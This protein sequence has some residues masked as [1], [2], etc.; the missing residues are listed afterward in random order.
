[1][2]SAMS[3]VFSLALIEGVGPQEIARRLVRQV[4]L[5][6]ARAL[7]VARTETIRTY[8]ESRL[9]TLEQNSVHGVSADVE[10]LTA[11]DSRVCSKCRGLEGNVYTIP[12]AR[13][14]IPVH[15]RCL[16]GDALI[17]ASPRISAVFKRWHQGDM[18]V[19]HTASG[20]NLT[21]TPNHPVL[22]PYGW[23]AAKLINAGSQVINCRS[24]DREMIRMHDNDYVPTS[25]EDVAESFLSSS[26]VLT[27]EMPMATEDFYGDGI[28]GDVYVVGADIELLDQFD[29]TFAHHNHQP[30]LD[31]R[32]S[33]LL[34]K[35]SL[36]DSAF[37]L[38]CQLS[39][40]SRGMSRFDL[41]GS[42]MGRHMLPSQKLGFTSGSYGNTAFDKPFPDGSSGDLKL[43]SNGILRHPSMV[44]CN[45]VFSRQVIGSWLGRID[46]RVVQDSEYRSVG[47]GDILS[48]LLKW[49]IGD[50][51]IDNVTSVDVAHFIGHVYDLQTDGGFF[52]TDEV[53]IS[54][55]RCTWLPANIEVSGDVAA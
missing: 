3:Q 22:T 41:P 33:S 10:F 8:A 4:G 46:T 2:S 51:S 14:V 45:D 43:G 55:C 26:Q 36:C 1:M 18:I 11:G 35:S 12:E 39:A 9:N 29:S 13:G 52:A 23:V 47:D 20:N 28:D 44:E 6:K 15:P 34:P 19:I 48:N 21:C 5:S 50:I 49:D 17:T 53:I 31:I 27:V 16:P 37:M 40:A 38:E 54:N 30:M 42:F 32:D 24:G 7:V 25:I